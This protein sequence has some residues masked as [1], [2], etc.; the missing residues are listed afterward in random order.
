M[1]FDYADHDLTGLMHTN[2]YKFTEGQ[3]CGGPALLAP[4]PLARG[5]GVAA[6]RST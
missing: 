4:A 2:N 6:Q 1:V 5:G 3:V